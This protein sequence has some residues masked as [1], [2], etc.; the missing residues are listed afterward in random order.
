MEW[1]TDGLQYED[2][3]RLKRVYVAKNHIFNSNPENGCELVVVM[4]N[5]LH[6][7]IPHV[8]VLLDGKLSEKFC[9]HSVVGVQFLPPEQQEVDA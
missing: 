8:A 9:L 5:G 4:E 2:G 3:Q 1:P 6:C 7:D